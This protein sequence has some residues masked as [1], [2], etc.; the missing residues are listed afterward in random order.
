[1]KIQI[2]SDPDIQKQMLGYFDDLSSKTEPATGLHGLFSKIMLH[3]YSRTIDAG[4]DCI[5]REPG[6]AESL[7][8]Q[9][10]LLA[11]WLIIGP[12]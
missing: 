1:M 12:T 7:S 2:I 4:G 11:I 5:S 6:D 8:D 10:Y 9:A 3:S